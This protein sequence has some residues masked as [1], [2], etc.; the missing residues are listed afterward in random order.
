MSHLTLIRSPNM[1]EEK[2]PA[3]STQEIQQ[4]YQNLAFKAGNLQ[5]AIVSQEK[6]LALLNE[7]LRNLNFEFVSARTAED[8]AR[9]AQPAAEDA[10][11]SQ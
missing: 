9:A 1:S 2:K 4:E 10:P 8:A 5:Y 7:Q 6:D 3:R 11:V